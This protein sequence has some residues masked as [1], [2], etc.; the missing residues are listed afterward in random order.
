MQK[1]LNNV[2]VSE[3]FLGFAYIATGERRLSPRKEN[4]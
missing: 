3:R 4:G 1:Y 2:T